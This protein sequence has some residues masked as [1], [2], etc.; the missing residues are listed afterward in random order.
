MIPKEELEK[1]GQLYFEELPKIYRSRPKEFADIFAEE[2]YP[3]LD[4]YND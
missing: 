1:Y 3:L 4:N 2:M